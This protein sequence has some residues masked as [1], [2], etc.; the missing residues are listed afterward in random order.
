MY[1]I[2]V[3]IK[4]KWFFETKLYDVGGG[5]KRKA[6]GGENFMTKV[7]DALAFIFKFFFFFTFVLFF[8]FG[9][10]G[11]DNELR[12]TAIHAGVHNDRL[13]IAEEK[14]IY[15]KYKNKNKRW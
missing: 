8:L 5:P 3:C 7:V 14:K 13:E 4:G 1:I 12:P 2:R 6:G 11:F 15:I 9:K 10:R